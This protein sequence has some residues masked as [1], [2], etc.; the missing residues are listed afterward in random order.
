[1][2][3]LAGDRK[4]VLDTLKSTINAFQCDGPV[5]Q[6]VM[7]AS[8]PSITEAERQQKRSEII[9]QLQ[10]AYAQALAVPDD[11]NWYMPRVPAVALFQT[12]MEQHLGPT[13]EVSQA[14][15]VV[16]DSG[17]PIAEKFGNT[18]PLWIECVLDGLETLIIGKAP[19]VTHTHLADFFYPTEDNCSIAL[20]ADWGADN[21][22]AQN[23]AVQMK[24][25]APD[26]AIHLGDIYYAGQESE[27][28]SFLY[29]FRDIAK[30]RS[31][32]LNGNH[33]MY[34]GGRSY[35]G[36]VLPSIQQSAS[37]FG[38]S[39][40]NWQFLGLDTAYV[41]HV[42]TS[43]SDA[44]LQNQ[45]DWTVDKV[46]SSDRATVVL[47]HHQPFSAYQPDHDAAAGLREDISRLDVAIQPKTLFAWFF[48][49]EHRCTIY[50][51]SFNDFK[52]R[53]I[54]NGCIPHLPQ[55]APDG[56]PP[57]PYKAINQAVRPDGSG[58]AMSGFVLLTLAGPKMKVEYINEDGSVFATENWVKP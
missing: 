50:D 10:N 19:F 4:A 40:T 34:T 25:S 8:F 43:P 5:I 54:G 48:G 36:K 12:A 15:G 44:R 16:D 2:N 21:D 3:E 18:D 57:V 26:Y 35:F 47:T 39:N 9:G 23:I 24:K 53:L 20:V 1:M 31:F 38:L 11:G 52:A 22:S 6:S 7:N 13:I 33:E 51:D 45:F 27:A 46:R 58:Y 37:Y 17:I 28:N 41:E 55:T 14:R 29:R 56:R 49:H 32:A 42:L 30:K